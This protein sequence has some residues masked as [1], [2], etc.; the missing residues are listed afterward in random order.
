MGTTIFREYAGEKMSR[1]LCEG[2]R[3]LAELYPRSAVRFRRRRL[4]IWSSVLV[5]DELCYMM[6]DGAIDGAVSES[7]EALVEFPYTL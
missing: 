1:S 7:S 2:K 3:K 4:N 6:L 5:I